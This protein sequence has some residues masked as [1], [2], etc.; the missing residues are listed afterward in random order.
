GLPKVGPGRGGGRAAGSV[1]K[2]RR[3]RHPLPAPTQP[4]P[5]AAERWVGGDLAPGEVKRR[6]PTLGW[7]ERSET[8][9]GSFL[10]ARPMMGFARSSTRPTLRSGINP[11]KRT[12]RMTDL[13]LSAPT[14]PPRGTIGWPILSAQPT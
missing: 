6:E 2:L 9:P 11:I 4:S 14:P 12:Q 3:R 5:R 1:L 10:A 13:A 8:R 7:V